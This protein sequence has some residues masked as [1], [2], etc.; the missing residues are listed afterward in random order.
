MK[1]SL[2]ITFV[3][4]ESQAKVIDAARGAGATGATI[5]S[6]RGAGLKEPKTFLGLKLEKPQ[7]AVLFLVERHHAS[8]I[9]HAIYTAG[10]MEKAH[11]GIVL[12]LPVDAAMGLESQ[13]PTLTEEAKEEYF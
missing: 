5:L 1:F 13:I 7:D 10:E 4:S 8:K 3:P 12:S 2:V 11:N 6:A 9:L